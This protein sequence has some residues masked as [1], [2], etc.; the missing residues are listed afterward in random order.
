MY[1]PSPTAILMVQSLQGSKVATLHKYLQHEWISTEKLFTF[2][3]HVTHRLRNV[4]H[5][6]STWRRTTSAIG[7]HKITHFNNYT[8][9]SHGS[10]NSHFL[11]HTHENH[12]TYHTRIWATLID[13]YKL[14]YNNLSAIKASAVPEFVWYTNTSHLFGISQHNSSTINSADDLKW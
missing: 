4:R 1:L 3:S 6:K 2:T 8:L 9:F 10:Q 14:L 11:I 13:T 7:C 5:N 12:C